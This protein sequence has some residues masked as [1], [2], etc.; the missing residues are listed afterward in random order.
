MKGIKL[1]LVSLSIIICIV[2]LY[3]GVG[4]AKNNK[5]KYLMAGMN[6]GGSFGGK[7]EEKPE[8]QEVDMDKKVE[9]LIE[10]LLNIS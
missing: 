1:K 7:K 8:S 10:S 3:C 2:L 4:I 9:S 6:F 5:I